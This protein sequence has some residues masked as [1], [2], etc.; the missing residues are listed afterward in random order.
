MHG[1]LHSPAPLTV[2][3]FS[4][5][6]IGFTFLVAAHPGSPGQRAV[7]RVCVC[8]IQLK[9]KKA[10]TVNLRLKPILKQDSDA[11]Q[12]PSP[13]AGTPCAMDLSNLGTLRRLGHD[14]TNITQQGR[15]HAP[16]DAL[17]SFDAMVSTC[18]YIAHYV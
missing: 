4:K 5:I 7:K 13:A 3:C 18:L 1:D 8:S 16:D 12:T 15:Y 10:L 14:E 11:L 6:Q 2:S 17:M 9:G